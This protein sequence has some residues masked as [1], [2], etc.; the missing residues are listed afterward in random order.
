MLRNSYRALTPFIGLL[1]ISPAAAEN[2][3][4]DDRTGYSY[5]SLQ[6][7]APLVRDVE[8]SVANTAGPA[9]SGIQNVRFDAGFVLDALYGYYFNDRLHGEIKVTYGHGIGPEITNIAGFA[10]NPNAGMTVST[11]G[12]TQA[13]GLVTNLRYD[14]HAFDNGTRLFAGIG[15]GIALTS[16]NGVGPT[17]SPFKIDDTDT[18]YVICFMGGIN[19]P[20]ANNLELTAQYTAIQITG[21]SYT[22]QIGANTL[23]VQAGSDL[24][25]VATIGFRYLFD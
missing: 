5:V 4:P 22:S 18:A 3:M 9:N 17:A 8:V 10:G 14:F 1:S 19:H 6:I 7:G 2:L 21:T 20:I 24:R 13:L 15:G 11:S 25:H 23:N 16:M 12:Y